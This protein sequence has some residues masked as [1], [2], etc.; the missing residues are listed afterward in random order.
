MQD[1]HTLTS[2]SQPLETMTGFCGFGLKRTQLTQSAWPFSV[3]VNL[4]S[5]S[6]FHSLMALSREPETIWRLSAEKDTDSTSLLWPTNRLVV[7]PVASS[8]SRRVLSHEADRAYAPSEEITY[9]GARAH[10][11]HRF[12]YEPLSSVFDSFR[13]I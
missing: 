13:L 9:S 8:Q 1:P 4:Q 12:F 10:G 3:I 7:V 2:L 11:S 6:V 5:P